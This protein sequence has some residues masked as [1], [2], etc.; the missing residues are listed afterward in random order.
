MAIEAPPSLP[1]AR[2][3]GKSVADL[4]FAILNS[5]R[6]RPSTLHRQG[7]LGRS[8]AI[9]DDQ[10]DAAS[11]PPNAHISHTSHTSH[12]SHLFQCSISYDAMYNQAEKWGKSRRRRRFRTP[13]DIHTPRTL[14]KPKRC[15]ASLATALHTLR[16]FGR[17]SRSIWSIPALCASPFG[18]ARSPGFKTRA[19]L[20]KLN[21]KSVKGAAGWNPN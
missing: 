14:P 2:T 6:A 8:P 13:G 5:E 21:R 7:G 3:P 1:H 15:R 9:Q 17:I 11:W 20:R 12:T 16:D 10:N 19:Y 4:P 18:V